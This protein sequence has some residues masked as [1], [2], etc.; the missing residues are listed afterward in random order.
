MRQKIF[1]GDPVFK[2]PKRTKRGKGYEINSTNTI[3]IKIVDLNLLLAKLVDS[4]FQQDLENQFALLD[5]LREVTFRLVTW[6]S[7]ESNSSF[8]STPCLCKCISW[9]SRKK[10]KVSAGSHPTLI[11]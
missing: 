5:I 10:K 1:L 11:S 8:K 2:I 3:A 4:I 9:N 7:Q 6:D